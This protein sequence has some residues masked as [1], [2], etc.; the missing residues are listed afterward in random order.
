VD[1]NDDGKKDLIAGDMRGNVW[2]F[3]NIGTGKNP[4]LAKGERV[5]A[6]GKPIC[7]ERRTYKREGGKYVVEK[8]TPGSHKLADRYS[9]IHM[10][11]WDGD[12]LKDLL[13]GHNST[14]VLYKN[15]GTRSAPRFQAPTLVEP[16][17]VSARTPA[18]RFP[19]RPSPYV[20]D[21][22]GDGKKDLLI[23]TEQPNLYFYRNIGSHTRPKLAEGKLLNLKGPG[24][25]AGHRW[26]IEV[27]DWNNDGKRDILVGNR[28]RG[29]PPSSGG[30]IWLFLGR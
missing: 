20:T 22:D 8:V 6:D 24:S 29:A 13:V 5:R 11:D 3:L 28:C 23:G 30:N 9:K 19:S 12:G 7:A 18:A 17:G 14:I 21:W 4:K 25:N 2:L 27:T 16:P 15:V 26:R 1:W 10:A